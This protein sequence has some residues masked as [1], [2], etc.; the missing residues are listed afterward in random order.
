MTK[1][2]TSEVINFW[3]S[4]STMKGSWLERGIFDLKLKPLWRKS[5][6]TEFRTA[7][8]TTQEMLPEG[9]SQK[10]NLAQTKS[11]IQISWTPISPHSN[12]SA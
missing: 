8:H 12:H 3:P 10:S 11:G 5:R 7:T 1:L 4:A 2:G 6:A 9:Q